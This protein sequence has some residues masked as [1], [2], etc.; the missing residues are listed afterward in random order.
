MIDDEELEELQEENQQLQ[1]EIRELK[2]E[3]RKSKREMTQLQNEVD[4]A[5]QTSEAL[6]NEL[7]MVQA[8]PKDYDARMAEL[9]QVKSKY[10]T[11]LRESNRQIDENDLNRKS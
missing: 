3:L 8:V 7:S 11:L 1:N 4:A 2:A 10:N 5:H 9:E 6:E